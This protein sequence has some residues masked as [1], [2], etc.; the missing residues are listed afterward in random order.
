MIEDFNYAALNPSELDTK[1]YTKTGRLR[2]PR[3]F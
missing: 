1:Q 3:F 2:K